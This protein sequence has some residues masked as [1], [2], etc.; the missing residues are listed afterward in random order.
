SG[1]IVTLSTAGATASFAD[2]NAG[3]N[4]TVTFSGYSVSGADAGNYN[5]SQPANSTANIT[6]RNLT[7]TASDQITTYGF[8]GTSAALGT[9]ALTSVGLQNGETIGSVMLTTDDT[10][11]TSGNYIVGTYTITP[12]AATGGTFTASNYNITYANAP[13]GL[14]VNAKGLTV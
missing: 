2:A 6:Q 13:T 5:F 9:S 12:S 11:S 4:K 1:D 8:G 3:N 14:T 10:T 7:I